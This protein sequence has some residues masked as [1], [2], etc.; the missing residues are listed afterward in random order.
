MNER[1]KEILLKRILDNIPNNVKPVNFLS[2][3]L[4][5]GKE[6]VY[7]RL[8]RQ[9]AFTLDEIVILSNE[10]NISLDQIR[11][12]YDGKLA[13]FSLLKG[14]LIS[15]EKGF[16]TRLQLFCDI[17]EEAYNAKDSYTYMVINRFLGTFSTKYPHLYKFVYYKWIHQFDKV[18]LNYYYSDL[19]IPEDVVRLTQKA[20][21]YQQ[22]LAKTVIWDES[23]YYNTIQ[24]IKYYQ[25]R[26]LIE[27]NDI[28]LIKGDLVKSLEGLGYVLNTGE[29]YVG[30]K[31]EVYLSSVKVSSNSS[32]LRYD[33]NV[34][35]SFW[36]HSDS[37]IVSLDSQVYDLQKEWVDSLKK[38][39]TLITKSN[40]KMQAEFLNKQ[41]KLLE[42]I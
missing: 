15:P 25:E 21:Y 39:S 13:D 10:L 38:Y 27:E 33:D 31:W 14:R 17:M 35:T 5:I 26:G 29:S 40:Q 28:L 9:I 4:D 32:C 16:L 11:S 42:E 41:Y 18:S 1:L 30:T 12:E 19:E 3:I 23:V 34:S 2:D 22:R 36:V 20:S 6:S 8:N 24:E 7:R 37:P